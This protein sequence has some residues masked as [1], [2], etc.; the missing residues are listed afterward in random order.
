MTAARAVS[1]PT[2]GDEGLDPQVVEQV[3]ERPKPS[4][5]RWGK[6]PADVLAAW[7]AV[8]GW[9][10]ALVLLA[11]SMYANQRGQVWASRERL[12]TTVGLGTTKLNEVLHAARDAG[13]LTWQPRRVRGKNGRPGNL[14]TLLPV[15]EGFSRDAA[16]SFDRT[17]A[18]SGAARRPKPPQVSAAPRPRTV[19]LNSEVEHPPTAGEG[20]SLQ[21]APS[22]EAAADEVV[23]FWQR[24]VPNIGGSLTTHRRHVL[25]L[26]AAGETVPELKLAILGAC[27]D[28]WVLGLDGSGSRREWVTVLR[29]VLANDQI[30]ARAALARAAT[31]RTVPD[32]VWAYWAP[33]F[34]LGRAGAMRR[35]FEARDV[36]VRREGGQPLGAAAAYGGMPPGSPWPEPLEAA[37]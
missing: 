22:V 37:G 35:L 23:G 36:Q 12:A 6:V 3:A 8:A 19:V 24:L 32:G 14:Y 34:K 17:A 21:D 28:P 25:P 20:A 13:L 26:L 7:V 11:L 16:E 10:G 18:E 27:M 1:A 29:Q 30:T 4:S 5:G 15:P 2:L 31:F 9:G 33:R